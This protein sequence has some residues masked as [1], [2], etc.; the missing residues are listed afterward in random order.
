MLEV[1][2]NR[3]SRRYEMAIEGSEDLALVFYQDDANGHRVLTRTEVPFEHSGETSLRTWHAVLS[4][5]DQHQV[6][7]QMSFHGGPALRREVQAGDG[8]ADAGE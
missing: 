1:I 5:G 6:H 3:E 7:P 8:A 4:T 2:H